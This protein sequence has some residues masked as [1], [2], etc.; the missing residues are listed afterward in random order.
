MEIK[1]EPGVLAVDLAEKLCRLLGKAASNYVWLKG[2]GL[3]KEWRIDEKRLKEIPREAID[4]VTDKIIE[5]RKIKDDFGKFI[6][7]KAFRTF[8]EKSGENLIK[9]V[10]GRFNLALGYYGFIEASRNRIIRDCYVSVLE[11]DIE[12]E[13]ILR[14]YLFDYIKPPDFEVKGLRVPTKDEA[15]QWLTNLL[16]NLKRLAQTGEDDTFANLLNISDEDIAWIVRT[17]PFI[18]ATEFLKEIKGFKSIDDAFRYILDKLIKLDLIDNK[19]FKHPIKEHI[20]WSTRSELSR[21][22]KK[23]V[24]DLMIERHIKVVDYRKLSHGDFRIIAEEYTEK[25]VD[26][27]LSYLDVK[28]INKLIKALYDKVPNIRDLPSLL[29]ERYVIFSIVDPSYLEKAK[30]LFSAYLPKYSETVNQIRNEVLNF[31]ALRGVTPPV[32]PP[33]KPEILPTPV[34]PE[35]PPEVP[36]IPEIPEIP[37]LLEI[38]EIPPEKPPEKPKKPPIDPREREALRMLLGLRPLDQLALFVE[39][40]T[41]WDFW[42]EEKKKEILDKILEG[43]TDEDFIDFYTQYPGKI[44]K[45]LEVFAKYNISAPRPKRLKPKEY[46]KL[47]DYFVSELSKYALDPAKYKD[48]FAKVVDEYKTYEENK[49]L[50]DDLLKRIIEEAQR[51]KAP[52]RL[53]PQEIAELKGFFLGKITGYRIPNPR[54]YLPQADAVIDPEKSYESNIIALEQLADKI[55]EEYKPPEKIEVERKTLEELVKK[56]LP[57]P[58]PPPAPIEF[59]PALPPPIELPPPPR[60]PPEP[61]VRIPVLPF[62]EYQVSMKCRDYLWKA[63]ELVE[64]LASIDTAATRIKFSSDLKKAIVGREY[65][66]IIDQIEE[67][68]NLFTECECPSFVE[69]V[70]SKIEKQGEG[71]GEK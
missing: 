12:L 4:A 20:E 49:A 70:R 39:Q 37:E 17:I 2:E 16:L 47:A 43:W 5:F 14:T 32:K 69:W 40:H 68:M 58:V 36:E 48:E 44:D 3:I 18:Y 13:D 26:E 59:P 45:A 27:V 64:K 54:Y 65:E 38:P 11:K 34:P 19:L 35:K 15:L 28:E 30:S 24:I 71:Q 31:I 22:V 46:S 29:V 57:P 41:K 63:W 33:E 52:K 42:T 66:K 8:V 51:E 53:T 67:N 25:Y 1:E 56:S 10:A 7:S 61:E 62:E 9:Y 21:V 50:V 6:K 60:P 55:L 23:R